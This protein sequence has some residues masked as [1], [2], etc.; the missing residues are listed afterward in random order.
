MILGVFGTR[1]SHMS[2]WRNVQTTAEKD[3]KHVAEWL[4]A[5]KQQHNIG[6]IVIDDLASYKEI[7]QAKR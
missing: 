3:K 2:G 6:A 4:K 7:A 5:L 1:L